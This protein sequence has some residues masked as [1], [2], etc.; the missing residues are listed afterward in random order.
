MKKFLVLMLV[1]FG[2]FSLVGCN[3]GEAPIFEVGTDE[4]TYAPAEL[5]GWEVE[6]T[7][8]V[9][10]MG[11][12]ND[13]IFN[14][15]VTVTSTN[16]TVYEAFLA[17]VQGKGISQTSSADSGWIQAIDSYENGTNNHY[18]LVYNNDESLLVGTNSSQIRNGD[19]IEFVFE[20]STY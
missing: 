18:W 11:P 12:D 8:Y 9:Q 1:F 13:E 3:E 19:Y 10:I 6:R 16:P 7:V 2:T 4:G 20:E 5:S 15:E 17:A 14:G